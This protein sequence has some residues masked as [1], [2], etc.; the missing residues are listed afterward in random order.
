[1]V[2][3]ADRDRRA[4]AHSIQPGACALLAR[5]MLLH[6]YTPTDARR[7]R[8]RRW[9]EFRGRPASVGAP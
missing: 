6:H 7:M 3:R 5:N 9:S 4:C 2:H 8:A 1:L